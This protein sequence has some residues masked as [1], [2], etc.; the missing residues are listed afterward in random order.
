MIFA[1]QHDAIK[2]PRTSRWQKLRSKKQAHLNRPYQWL[3]AEK[4]FPRSTKV[5]APR[6]PH[7]PGFGAE[8][9]DLGNGDRQRRGIR[10][11]KQVVL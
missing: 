7:D 6:D 5:W 11:K 10:V 4:K 9:R 8:R 3:T 2:S 1:A